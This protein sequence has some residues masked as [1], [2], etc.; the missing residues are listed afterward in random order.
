MG[1]LAEHSNVTISGSV[2]KRNSIPSRYRTA[3][4]Y[5]VFE[6]AAIYMRQIRFRNHVSMTL[7]ISNSEFR[8]NSIVRNPARG[9]AIYLSDVNITISNSIFVNNS[10]TSL[11]GAIY[12]SNE[13]R[14]DDRVDVLIIQSSFINNHADTCGGAACCIRLDSNQPKLLYQ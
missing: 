11:G 12:A 5:S 3:T 9:G 14:N 13:M 2:F 4:V 6:G 7:T 8:D 1:L 10:A